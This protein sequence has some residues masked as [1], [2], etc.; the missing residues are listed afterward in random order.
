MAKIDY[1]PQ[2]ND[3][4][5]AKWFT[6]IPVRPLPKGDAKQPTKETHV[7][8]HSASDG[9]SKGG[10]SD[11]VSS[12]LRL[13]FGAL[14]VWLSSPT[15]SS[16]SYDDGPSFD[17]GAH[18]IEVEYDKSE[19]GFNFAP[20]QDEKKLAIHWQVY[21]KNNIRSAKL[22]LFAKGIEKALWTRKFGGG[23]GAP[24]DADFTAFALTDDTGGHTSG[25][26]IKFTEIKVDPATTAT[27]A[28][29]KEE[30][31]FAKGHLTL[32]RS[33]YMLKLSVTGC[34]AENSPVDGDA[35]NY[36]GAAWTYL[37][38]AASPISISV[39]KKEWLDDKREDIDEELRPRVVGDRAK[40]DYGYE[41]KILD[42]L[43]NQVFPKT[44]QN[45]EKQVIDIPVPSNVGSVP[46]EFDF[47]KRLWGDGPRLPLVGF[48]GV[49]DV[50]GNVLTKGM[51]DVIKGAEVVWDWSDNNPDRWQDTL[52][53]LL[54]YPNS[55]TPN[56]LKL[57]YRRFSTT[58]LPAGSNNCPK[59]YG[60]KYGDDTKPIFPPQDGKGTFPYV[61]T[62]LATRKWAVRTTLDEKGECAVI[63]NPSRFGGDRYEVSCYIDQPVLETTAAS[64][65]PTGTAGVG[66]T[67][68]L[69]I[70]RARTLHHLILGQLT[71]FDVD[72]MKTEA[73]LRAR[74]QAS[75][76]L[77]IT[78]TV[79]DGTEYTKQLKATLAE[80]LKTKQ[81]Y[82]QPFVGALFAQSALDSDSPP[83]TAAFRLRSR[84]DTKLKVWDIFARGALIRVTTSPART[85]SDALVAAWPQ[86]WVGA[87]SGAR[88][89]LFHPIR[90]AQDQA[91]SESWLLSENATAFQDGEKIKGLA[92]GHEVTI[93]AV[94]TTTSATQT[95]VVITEDSSTGEAAKVKFGGPWMTLR[96]TR[97]PLSRQ[98]HTSLGTAEKQ[99]LRDAFKEAVKT[100]AITSEDFKIE[101]KIRADLANAI[102][103]KALL[104][105]FLES[106]GRD[107]Q[108]IIDKRDVF[109]K[110]QPRVDQYFAG[111]WRS[112]AKEN[113]LSMLLRAVAER[114]RQEKKLA[115][116]IFVG[117]AQRATNL[118]SLQY[119]KD[120]YPASS[121]R[122]VAEDYL[123]N[124]SGTFYTDTYVDDPFFKLMHVTTP[125]STDSTT[126]KA[127][128]VKANGSVF[129]H[130]LGHALGIQHSPYSEDTEK[131]AKLA[132]K[133]LPD[134]GGPEPIQHLVDDGCLMD[135]HPDTHEFCAI[136]RLRHRGW[137]WKHLTNNIAA[138]KAAVSVEIGDVSRLFR[139]GVDTPEGQIERLQVLGLFTRSLN[140]P[141]KSELK[142]AMDA[143]IAYAKKVLN[144]PDLAA[145]GAL[146]GLVKNFLVD[147]GALPTK[148]TSAK[149]RLPNNW[150]PLYSVID[151]MHFYPKHADGAPPNRHDFYSLGADRARVARE[152]FAANGALG[153]IPLRIQV[154]KVVT[155]SKP[156][157]W[158]NAQV[159]IE[160]VAVDGS[161]VVKA[162]TSVAKPTPVAGGNTFITGTGGA[163]IKGSALFYMNGKVVGHKAT[164][165]DPQSGNVHFEM[166]GKRG[167]QPDGVISKSKDGIYNLLTGMGGEDLDP[168]GYAPK[169]EEKDDGK[170]KKKRNPKNS[171]GQ[172]IPRPAK[173][174]AVCVVADEDGVVEVLFW[175]SQI[176]GDRYKLNIYAYD[177]Y[178]EDT[179]QK[180]GEVTTGTLVR[181]RT[182]RLLSYFNVPK[183]VADAGVPQ[184]VRDLNSA[185]KVQALYGQSLTA[186]IKGRISLELAKSYNELVLA[187][188]AEMPQPV[189]R[190][191]WA[192]IR[193]TYADYLTKYPDLANTTAGGGV[194]VTKVPL[195]PDG[196]R[197]VWT[198]AL[199]VKPVKGTVQIRPLGGGPDESIAHD[200]L[201]QSEDDRPAN[202]NLVAIAT[203]GTVWSSPMVKKVGEKVAVTGSVDYA[204][205][206][207][208]ITFANT[209]P[210]LATYN[211]VLHV[212][213]YVDIGGLLPLATEMP[214][215][216]P[217]LLPYQHPTVYN[218]RKGGGYRPIATLTAQAE[219][220]EIKYVRSM[221][222][223][224]TNTGLLKAMATSLEG[225]GQAWLPGVILIQSTFIDPFAFTY[226]GTQEGKG[227]GNVLF[228]FSPAG[229]LSQQKV[230][231]LTAHELSHTLYLEHA[232]GEGTQTG[233]SPDTHDP[234]EQA[235][236]MTY[237][238]KPLRE[239]C[240]GCLAT[241]R[242]IKMYGSPLTNNK[243]HK[244]PDIAP[245]AEGEDSEEDAIPQDTDSD[246]VVSPGAG[247]LL[248]NMVAVGN[249]VEEGSAVLV[250]TDE[251]LE[252][253]VG[254]PRS[255]K[256]KELKFKA[257]DAVKKNDVLL[258][259]EP[260]TNDFVFA[261]SAGKLVR[262]MVA[263]GD[264]LQAG[265]AVAE[266]EDP[267]LKTL[268]GAP[269][270]GKVQALK[271]K[272]GDVVKKG[273]VLIELE[274]KKK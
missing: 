169:V 170:R 90:D 65:R 180:L 229:D 222:G 93:T 213:D 103:R 164:G 122:P 23:F 249:L 183:P 89:I 88:S 81:S 144:L 108:L 172:P 142:A 190:A 153:A 62:A 184:F 210:L 201:A 179:S 244:F 269:R 188:G 246:Q 241:L 91:T 14:K 10:S 69:E 133:K 21:G 127:T 130:E 141:F 225:N 134:T 205:G 51:A 136:C 147:G 72:A 84:E 224:T 80:F 175:P 208:T 118:S 174:N 259:L 124:P 38:V 161:T 26:S 18:D 137:N 95:H 237:S 168:T 30:T 223:V 87:K 272:A 194:S 42:G 215:T 256:V 126:A 22:E 20:T 67:G 238:S 178:K 97:K 128:S 107:E 231:D 94:G 17:Y 54:A 102:E 131:R 160:L 46:D 255:G 114:L 28:N 78:T 218:Q 16:K 4:Q 185:T 34:T 239:H 113:V 86:V 163:Q 202:A 106:L 216:T 260:L 44:N 250:L 270:S 230:D 2:P 119:A 248:R 61:V 243:K 196:T 140:F 181:W 12:P 75:V 7:A 176:G 197:K 57:L 11:T 24:Q 6:A 104:T 233:A 129:L 221:G 109:A 77:D 63:F 116:G 79:W 47:Y 76:Q 268:V 151:K 53:P 171:T 252:M 85:S 99:V 56:Y 191:Q 228:L 187:P 159:F 138:V 112:G 71:N 154:Q 258:V 254:A 253:L 37:H 43:K 219:P 206:D 166:G 195:V 217:F 5:F 266:I 64:F 120:F 36:P 139:R 273:D 207:V 271:H 186:D 105:A 212:R 262:N 173:P 92:S 227:W 156:Q 214:R 245:D 125:D 55:V 66:T 220:T 40:S 15:R 123:D 265:V 167:M 58:L 257:G 235:C 263:V 9:N 33:P 267:M 96:Y 203:G 247:K 41:G 19:A 162:A 29:G 31:P 152:I 145:P 59:E 98:L 177:P 45:G 8:I 3:K 236:L 1:P 100:H 48:C 146:D 157:A 264:V 13:D 165:G 49:L 132:S 155:K 150:S 211:V 149:M 115:E 232:P 82:Q 182:Q 68:P 204:T 110:F 121:S 143:S 189:T 111:D 83:T 274:P 200:W 50:D 35:F 73:V 74:K 148:G 226:A 135:Y 198:V 242:G 117:H 193:Q 199:P 240:G 60:G 234:A 39:G 261:P 101:V 25:G 70:V 52:D 27:G 32:A 158:A 192:D 209:P 251:S